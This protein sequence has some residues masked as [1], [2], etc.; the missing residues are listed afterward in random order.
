[1]IE[2]VL[3]SARRTRCRPFVADSQTQSVAKFP[4]KTKICMAKLTV[5]VTG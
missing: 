1:M 5:E 3:E 4:N 2:S